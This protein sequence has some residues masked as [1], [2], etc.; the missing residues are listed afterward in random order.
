MFTMVYLANNLNVKLQI[1]LQNFQTK[2][3][4]IVKYDN[5][6]CENIIFVCFKI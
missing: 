1:S 5:R 3:E 4:E 6:L 2:W